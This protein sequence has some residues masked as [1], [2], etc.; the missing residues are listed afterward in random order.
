[1]KARQVG[2]NIQVYKTL[3][4]TWTL[5]GKHI[6][7]FRQADNETLVSAGFYDVV[8]PSF[9]SKTQ[10]KGG[11]YFDEENSVFTY[12]V[13]DI[14]FSATRVI[15]DENGEDTEET[16]PIY[17][18]ESKKSDIISALKAEA[19]KRLQPTDWQVVR[20]YERSVDIDTD[21]ATERANILSELT[22]KENEVNDLTSYVDLIN[23]DMRFFPSEPEEDV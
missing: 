8:Y 15:V 9:N 1:M 18:I 7:N 20:K 4:E 3:P 12:N 17:N 10:T 13:T 14:D 21:T 6:V 2:N 16:E 11:L 23:Y 19:N 5:A 22:R